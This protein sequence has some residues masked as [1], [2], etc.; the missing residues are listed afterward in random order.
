[1][2]LLQPRESHARKVTVAHGARA[3]SGVKGGKSGKWE[4]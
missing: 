4:Y 3:A 2:M 1:M